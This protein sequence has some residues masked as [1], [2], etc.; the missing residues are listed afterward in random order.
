MHGSPAGTEGRKALRRDNKRRAVNS[1]WLLHAGLFL[2]GF[3]FEVQVGFEALVTNWVEDNSL[4]TGA[5]RIRL[6]LTGSHKLQI[7]FSFIILS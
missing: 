6:S 3:Y 2:S 7:V 4:F 1:P 5:E